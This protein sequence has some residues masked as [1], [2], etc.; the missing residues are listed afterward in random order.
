MSDY[1]RPRNVGLWWLAILAF[2]G[3]WFIGAY[4]C[5]TYAAQVIGGMR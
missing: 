1:E 5:V 3:V 2:C 4:R